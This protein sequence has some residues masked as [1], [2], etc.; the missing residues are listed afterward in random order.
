[1][2]YLGESSLVG[3]LA[4]YARHHRFLEVPSDDGL[5]PK[6]ARVKQWRE[7]VSEDFAFSVVLPRK[8]AALESIDGDELQAAL[9]FADALQAR[10]LLL[11]TPSSVRP[12]TRSKELIRSLFAKIAKDGRNIAWDVSGMWSEN[13][14]RDV[15]EGSVSADSGVLLVDDLASLKSELP[16]PGECSYL[17]FRAL[18]QFSR[19][20]QAMAQRIAEIG[21]N[22]S[23]I[24]V[25]LP[26]KA[27]YKARKLIHEELGYLASEQV[28]AGG[29]LLEVEAEED[30]DDMENW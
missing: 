14:K 30:D 4:K 6:A 26:S 22:T 13:D 18:G 10:W 1:M 16:A 23:D 5:R 8:I 29:A 11:L 28:L 19:F 12:T 17:R 25:A 27:A 2:I 24:F 9:A 3:E 20:S 7:V 15:I 21:E